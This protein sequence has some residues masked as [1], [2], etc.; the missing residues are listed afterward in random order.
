MKNP[1]E[2]KQIK[3]LLGKSRLE[4]P[5][6]DFEHDVMMQIEIE[7]SLRNASSSGIAWSWVFFI[8]GTVFG[9][10]L[11]LMIPQLEISILG[12]G[13]GEMNLLFQV[14]FCLFVL[15]HL[16]KLIGLTNSAEFGNRLKRAVFWR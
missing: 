3:E 5:F 16:E 6:P 8:A 9:I 14:G 7:E 2:D 13:A 10:L 4:M 11:T 15:L 12:M 1:N